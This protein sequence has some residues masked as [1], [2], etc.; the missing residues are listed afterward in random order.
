MPGAFPGN[1]G[2]QLKRRRTVFYYQWV[3][4][5]LLTQAV[6]FIGPHLIWRYAS[7]R[8]GV[9]VSSVIET[10]QSYQKASYVEARDQALRYVVTQVI[11]NYAK[12]FHSICMTF[13]HF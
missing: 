11:Q 13:Y 9:D 1:T 10:A 12:R 6:M 8:V 3:P 2:E 5:V 4:F 7:R